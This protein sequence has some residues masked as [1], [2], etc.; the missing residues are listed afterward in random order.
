MIENYAL[1]G[2]KLS[3]SFSASYFNNKFENN[4][5]EANYQLLE[6]ENLNTLLSLI[7]SKNLKGFNITIPFKQ[8][9]IDFLDF[10]SKEVEEI[11]ACNCVKV[12]VNNNKKELHGFN[13]DSFGFMNSI[14]PFLNNT[15]HKALIFGTGGASKAVAYVL[16]KL[17]IEYFF[18]SRKVE[19][20]KKNVFTYESVNKYMLENCKLIINTTPIGMYGF[21][22]QNLPIS[23]DGIGTEHLVVDLIYNPTETPFLKNALNQGA[24]ILNGMD[25]LKLQAEKSW[26]IWNNTTKDL[27]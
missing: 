23:Y 24:K 2:K 13:T 11:G 26:E 22:Q 6:L 27:L 8:K 17:G 16:K 19:S 5:I 4:S 15:H 25:M 12:V 18:I 14:K 1:I 9:V 21:E 20:S 10:R 3:H 7:D